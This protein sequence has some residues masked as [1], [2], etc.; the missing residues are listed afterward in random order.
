MNIQKRINRKQFLPTRKQ[1]TDFLLK[2]SEGITLELFGI[3][4]TTRNRLPIDLAKSRFEVC[5]MQYAM[6]KR[7]KMTLSQM[8]SRYCLIRGPIISN[9]RLC[10]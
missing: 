3:A 10:P 5:E 2:P 9:Q 7:I 1:F 8:S 4:S 6:Y